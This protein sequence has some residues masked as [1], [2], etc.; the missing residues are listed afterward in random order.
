MSAECRVQND[1]SG[2]SAGEK[3]AAWLRVFS[4]F[5]SALI[6]YHSSLNRGFPWR[7]C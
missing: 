1:E 3:P 5:H 2:M 6:N 4:V 7:E